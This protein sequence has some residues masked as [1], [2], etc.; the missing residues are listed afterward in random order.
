MMN[1][2]TPKR[3]L[4]EEQ[5]ENNNF[6]RREQRLQ[7]ENKLVKAQ[8]ELGEIE[9]SK[10]VIPELENEIIDNVEDPEILRKKEIA[11]KRKKSLE[12]AR[13]KIKS[14]TQIK[15]E[16]IADYNRRFNLE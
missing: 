11:E 15:Q 9:A 10:T 13:S 6:K 12:M 7:N 3:I 8:N 1:I 14:K 4:T 2:N 5:K 16:S